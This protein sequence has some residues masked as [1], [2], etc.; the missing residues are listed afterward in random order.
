MQNVFDVYKAVVDNIE[1]FAILQIDSEGIIT[2]WNKGAERI[3]GYSTN[4]MVGSHFKILFTGEELENNIPE[5]LIEEATEKGHSSYQGWRTRKDGSLFYGDVVFT[6]LFDKDNTLTGYT[7]VVHDITDSINSIDTGNNKSALVNDVKD[8]VWS[9]DKK[10]RLLASNIQFVA[11]VEQITGNHV[12]KGDDL[13]LGSLGKKKLLAFKKYYDRA[14]A[15]ESFTIT[16]NILHPS[17]QWFEVSFRPVFFENKIVGVG[18]IG[19]DI[20][21]IKLAEKLQEINEKRYRSLIENSIDGIVVLSAESKP[22]FITPSVK[23]IVGYTPSELMEMNLFSL[24]HPDDIP[25]GQALI[26]EVFKNPGVPFAGLVK[27]MRHK[28]G[29]WRW[30]EFT[31][32]NML[33]DPNINGIVENFRDIT[34]RKNDEI[35]LAKSE[36]RLN[37]AQQIA[38]L[39]SWELDCKKGVAILSDELCRMYGLTTDNN[40]HPFEDWIAYVHPDDREAVRSIIENADISKLN[41]Q[42]SFRVINDYGE[43]RNHQLSARYILDNDKNLVQVQGIIQDITESVHAEISR[44]QSEIRFKSLIENSKEGV[45]ILSV[46]GDI[47]YMSPSTTSILGYTS[48]EMSSIN[49]FDLVHPD[50]VLPS[51]QAISKVLENPG[52]PM[53][54]HTGRM[55]HKDGTWRWIEAIVTNLLH[56]PSIG[57]IVDNFRDVTESK[58]AEEKIIH[59]NR[60]YSF[61]SQVN[62][63]IIHIRDEKL[64]LKEVCNIAVETGKFKMAWMG[65][66]VEGYNK[67]EPFISTGDTNN[68]LDKIEISINDNVPEGFGPAGNAYRTGKSYFCNDIQSEHNMASWQKQAKKSDYRSNICIPVF[69]SGKIVYTFSLY[70]D[71][72]NFFDNEEVKLLDEVTADISYAIEAI[73]RDIMAKIADEKLKQSAIR[74][75]KAQEIAHYGACELD[76]STGIATWSEELCKIYGFSPENRYY[77]MDQWFSFIHPDDREYVSNVTKVSDATL[78]NEGFYHRIIRKDGQVRYLKTQSVYE[79]S[80][81]GKPLRLYAVSLDVTDV[82]EAEVKLNNEKLKLKQAQKI[83]HL[84]SWEF[85]NVI[86]KAVW[87]EEHCKIYGV[88]TEN[89]T[90]TLDAWLSFVHPE[91]RENVEMIIGTH[92]PKY[93]TH[94]FYHRIIRLDGSVRFLY[95]DSY[96]DYNKEGHPI[97]FYGI[98]YDITDLK[99]TEEKL[100]NANRLLSFKNQINYAILHA[101]DEQ[102]LFNEACRCGVELG[103]FELAWIGK[104][105]VETRRVRVMAHANAIQYDLD[106]FSNVI[107]DP[108]GAHASVMASGKP[109]VVNDFTHEPENSNRRIFTRTRGFESMLVLPL[110]KNGQT[111]YTMHFFSAKAGFFND[112]EVVILSEAAK[113]ISFALDMFDNE[114]LRKIAEDKLKHRNIRLKQAQE[115]AHFGG[116]ELDFSTGISHWSEQMCKIYGVPVKD[117]QQTYD[118]WLSFIHPDDLE[119]VTKIT[120]EADELLSNV[121]FYHRIIRKDGQVR[122][123]HTRRHL[124]VDD[125]NRPIGIYSVAHDITDIKEAEEAAKQSELNIRKIV[126]LLPQSIFVKNTAGEYVFANN[127]FAQLVGLNESEI[128]SKQLTEIIPPGNDILKLTNHEMEVLKRGQPLTIPNY[129][130]VDNEGKLHVFDITKVPYVLPGSS[131]KAILGIWSDITDKKN[132]ELERNN[133]VA[134]IMLRNQDL[135]QFSFI[136]SHNLRAPVANVIGITDLLLNKDFDKN[137]ERDF[138]LMLSSS[139]GKLDNVIKDLNYVLQYKHEVNERRENISFALLVSEVKIS[140]RKL[141]KNED[142]KIISDFT[143]VSEMF[144]IK[145]YLYS[146]FMNLISNSIKYRQLDKKPVIEIISKKVNNTIEITFRD[147]GMGIDMVRKGDQVFGLYKRFHTHTEGKGMGLFMVKTQVEALGGTISVESEVNVGTT[148]KILFG[149]IQ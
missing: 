86:K 81:D 117:C 126:D 2:F 90:Y 53:P 65:K 76:F 134:D 70:S 32:T 101:K 93:Q 57:G 105:N 130:F 82:K 47:I 17:E 78:N 4:E 23:A 89:N 91:D 111:I 61:I 48:E 80:I 28:D 37:W 123:I 120:K 114:Q 96:I 25:R 144:T 110:S 39:G 66:V 128:K 64:L 5:K 87:S 35:A 102:S 27:Q 20:T 45:A 143:S 72:V 74:L 148:F 13:C 38:H 24:I 98:S 77:N 100:V 79:Q 104:P 41:S 51:L 26:A 8:L 94:S 108:K 103:R 106:Y 125:F 63:A 59:A 10:F 49:V 62:K 22:V 95:S 18:C 112:D 58:I 83:A 137:E 1:D 146:I 147:N 107:Y 138:L 15:G 141:F 75:K 85:D 132:A 9:V 122:H 133:M 136:V 44:Q 16:D 68:Y 145:N 42:L 99:A 97:G 140:I 67:V 19:H 40:Q 119:K 43:I 33:N 31:I 116:D 54:G 131:E 88:S 121:S 71:E 124:E 149:N 11:L 7:K 3:R 6:A 55:R 46:E 118:S 29:S 14:F 36:E 34:Q 12:R 21:S 50:D 52:I 92:L 60:L 56:D 84:G 30:V 127:S 73:E 135:E 69:K 113:D 109:Y 139:V 142:L 129:V 115:I